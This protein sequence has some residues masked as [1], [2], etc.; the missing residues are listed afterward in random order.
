LKFKINWRITF[1]ND[2]LA[3]LFFVTIFD[4]INKRKTKFKNK[5]NLFN[6]LLEDLIC[7]GLFYNHFLQFLDNTTC[8]Q[9]A[10]FK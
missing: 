8:M 2:F 9:M 3:A 7:V 4:I 10:L 1:G 6:N 5:G